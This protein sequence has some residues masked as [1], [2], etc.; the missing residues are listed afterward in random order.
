LTALAGVPFVPGMRNVNLADCSAA[1][2]FSRSV[3]LST[4]AVAAVA[5]ALADYPRSEHDSPKEMATLEPNTRFIDPIVYDLMKS[6]MQIDMSQWRG[7][8]V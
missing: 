5:G 7:N 4:P 1:S 3:Q 8:I 2:G 6:D